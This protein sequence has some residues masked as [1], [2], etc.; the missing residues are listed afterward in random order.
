[1]AKG[2][3]NTYQPSEKDQ[4]ALTSVYDCYQRM[5]RLRARSFN[6][7]GGRDLVNFIDDSEKRFNGYVPPR[8]DLQMDW[9]ARVFLNF[10]QQQVVS[11]LAKTSL[12]RPK[13]KI[14]ATS[15]N[16]FV[17]VRKADVLEKGYAYVQNRQNGNLKF[18]WASMEAVVK[19]TAIT[20]I[21]YKKTKRTVREIDKYDPVTGKVESH[22][23]EIIDYDDVWQETVPLTDFFVENIFQPEMQLQPSVCWRAIMHKSEAAIELKKF[24]NWDKVMAGTFPAAL[25]RHPFFRDSFHLTLETEQV[26]VLRFYQKSTDRHVIIANGVL[27]YDGPFPFKH[28]EYPFSK[29]IYE[30]FGMQFFYGN[31]LP[32]KIATQQDVLNTLW[33]MG[34]D[35]MYLSIFK[36]ILTDDPDE[37]ED[38]V[39]VP[40][41][42]RKV[43]DINKYKVMNELT[44]PDASYFNMLQLAQKFIQEGSGTIAGGAQA[45]SMR[46]GSVTARQALMVEERARELLGLNSWLFEQYERDSCILTVKTFLQFITQS[47]K[48]SLIAGDDSTDTFNKA[49]HKILRVDDSKLSDGTY[50][51]TVIKI[52]KSEKGL[53]TPMELNIEEETAKLQG[54]NL[55]IMIVTADY[56]RNVQLDVTIEP[57]S[58]FQQSK[59][60]SQALALERYQLLVQNP[61]VDQT[62][63]LRDLLESY[64]IDP[65]KYIQ[66]Q[67]QMPVGMPGA[68]PGM[69]AGILGRGPEAAMAGGPPNLGALV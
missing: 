29:A 9:Q 46:G 7:F 21:G 32:N 19:G 64:D 48:L 25:E 5:V 47:E 41:L 58:A 34:L 33:N 45:Q 66:Q 61:A 30:P 15:R 18:F 63:N 10:T 13:P 50:G 42:I 60:V 44:G 1:M 12:N 26:E 53:P 65:E 51:T 39:L 49:F 55:E 62:E 35:Q 28:K 69:A 57:Q 3:E 31:S 68:T 40:G 6:Y 11:Y 54:Q 36:P 2:F 17:D 37:V 20:Y 38:T 4:E 16:S 52:A 8:D 23:R 27:L 22:E 43:G 24:K 14:T 59:S 67:P 56:I